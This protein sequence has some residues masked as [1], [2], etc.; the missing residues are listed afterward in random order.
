VAVDYFLKL[1]GVRGG[2]TDAKH[3][4]EIELLSFSLAAAQSAAPGA[5]GGGGAGKVQISGLACTAVTGKAGPQL[6]QLCVEGKHV[7][8]GLL[9]ARKTGRAPFEFLKIKLEDVVVSS[10][11]V[12]GTEADGPQDAFSL[13]FKRVSYDFVPQKPDGSADTPVHSGWDLATNKKI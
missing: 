1:D 2:S 3:K 9:T 5:G 12:G 13:A 11:S 6:F 7:K 4:D 10:Y 8:Q